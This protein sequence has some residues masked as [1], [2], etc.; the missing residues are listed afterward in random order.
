[1]GITLTSSAQS[2][3][4]PLEAFTKWQ[5]FL[6]FYFFLIYHQNTQRSVSEKTHHE[7]I[8]YKAFTLSSFLST[9][10]NHHFKYLR[11]ILCY[12]LHDYF[13]SKCV[14]LI[15]I[16]LITGFH[17]GGF[18]WKVLMLPNACNLFPFAVFLHCNTS[19]I[20]ARFFHAFKEWFCVAMD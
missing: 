17:F 14:P 19:P 1:M 5:L 15:I 7:G 10:R 3:I 16:I 18:L 11:H 2:F 13:V 9:S 20:V 8:M 6:W 4:T 12:N